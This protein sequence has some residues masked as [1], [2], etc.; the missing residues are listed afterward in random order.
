AA[1]PSSPA[2]A[3]PSATQPPVAVAPVVGSGGPA[4]RPGAA[5]LYGGQYTAAQSA[6]F[7]D[8]AGAASSSGISIPLRWIGWGTAVIVV[9]SGLFTAWSEYR[10]HRLRE[11]IDT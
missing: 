4:A 2:A 7:A 3:P 11:L 9:A 5:G 10:L 1:A 6:V 8:S